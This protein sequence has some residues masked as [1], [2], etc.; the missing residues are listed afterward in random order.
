MYIS[1][2]ITKMSDM[3]IDRLTVTYFQPSKRLAPLIKCYY[4]MEGDFGGGVSDIFFADG[5]AE[6][7]INV[8]IDFYREG[9]KETSAK[10]IG[11]IT[12]P[13][14]AKAL[15]KGKTFGVWFEPHGLSAFVKYRQ[16]ELTNSVVPL[17]DV[18]DVAEI[19]F[20]TNYLSSANIENLLPVVN[21]WF[22]NKILQ[23]K[24]ETANRMLSHILLQLKTDPDID[25]DAFCEQLNISRRYLEMVFSDK[26]G[27][28]P[29]LLSR[30][31]KFQSSLSRI[32]NNKK[33]LTELGYEL[34]YFDQSHFIREFKRFSGLKPSDYKQYKHRIN[35]FIQ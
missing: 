21:Q 31:F 35:K 7:V 18:F 1:K 22:E 33:K 32:Q 26:I 11:Q 6:I 29:R 5:C 12:D 23:P 15:G 2:K 3:G 25:L 14:E 24:D 20:I 13:F 30:I 27:V 4:L 16:S 10:I 28:S 8:G 9:K 34:D 19:Q 17:E